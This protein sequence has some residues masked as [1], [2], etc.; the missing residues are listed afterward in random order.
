MLTDAQPGGSS[1]F[2][3]TKVSLA[4]VVEVGVIVIL[5][6]WITHRKRRTLRASTFAE[7]P[8]IHGRRH[9][10]RLGV[11]LLE[12]IPVVKYSAR[13]PSNDQEQA[14]DISDSAVYA[15]PLR[16]EAPTIAAYPEATEI[17]RAEGYNTEMIVENRRTPDYNIKVPKEADIS[18]NQGRSGL[19]RRREPLSCSVCTE[20]FIE[21]EDIRILPCGH[22]HH[23]RCIDPWLLGFAATCPLW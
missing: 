20:N 18:Q 7:P 19:G 2:S 14:T 4:L 6:A 12:S 1:N 3:N 10:N 23:Q 17:A 15:C 11:Y 13:P 21:N 22:M 8:R 16:S 9:Q 5:A